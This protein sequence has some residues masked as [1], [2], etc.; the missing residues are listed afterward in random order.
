MNRQLFLEWRE[1]EGTRA[2]FRVLRDVIEDHKEMLCNGDMAGEKD[3]A[4]AYMNACG[5]I[6]GLRT[7]LEFDPTEGAA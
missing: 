2:Y 3:V 6:A 7:A 5:Y 4:A 1:S